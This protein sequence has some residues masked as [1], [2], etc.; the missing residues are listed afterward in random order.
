MARSDLQIIIH[1]FV[2]KE[3]TKP[4]DEHNLQVPNPAQAC[5]LAYM[6]IPGMSQLATNTVNIVNKLVTVF[7]EPYLDS[8]LVS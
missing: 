8:L 5:I 2:L 4:A 7:A 6:T 3:V 1:G